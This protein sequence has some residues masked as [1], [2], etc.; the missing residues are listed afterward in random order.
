MNTNMVIALTAIVAFIIAIIIS[1]I[2]AWKR[3]R[4]TN[5]TINVKPF[6]KRDPNLEKDLSI[7]DVV[8]YL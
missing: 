1:V 8:R 4:P 5:P 2:I 3:T 7:D 6:V